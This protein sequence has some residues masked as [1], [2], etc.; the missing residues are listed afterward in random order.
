MTAIPALADTERRTEYLGL[1]DDVGP[2]DVDFDV[3]GNSTDYGQWIE[4]WLDGVKL[5]A[6]T[7]YTLDSPSGSLATLARPIQD[8]R[9]TPAGAYEDDGFTGDLQI[10]GADRPRRTS[11]LTE[12]QGVSAHDAN[13][14]FTQIAARL[15]ELWDMLK[16][17]TV[18]GRP[19]EAVDMTLPP[20]S[21]RASKAF[22]FDSDGK[23]DVAE[24]TGAITALENNQVTN[25][26]L[27][28]SGACSVIGRSAN[29]AGDPADISAGS[30]GLILA[31]LTN[32]VAF[33]TLTAILDAVIGS[34]RGMM[35][36]RGAV[37]WQALAI[38]S[39][40]ALLTSDGTDP[41]WSSAASQLP[42]G[43]IDGC[44]LSNNSGDATND[45]DFAAGK[46]RNST[47][48]VNITC[49]ALT[50]RLDADWAAGTNQ[51]MRY[52]GAAIANTTYHLYSIAK[53]DG[54]QD[55][56]AYTGLDPTAVL[57]TDY[58]YF[59]RIG[60]IVRSSAAILGFIQFGD[61]FTLKTPFD[62]GSGATIDGTERTST[63]AAVPTGIRVLATISFWLSSTADDRAYLFYPADGTNPTVTA[64]AGPVSAGGRV[65]DGAGAAAAQS[66]IGGK[67]RVLTDTNAQFKRKASAGGT[68]QTWT[69]GYRDLRGKDA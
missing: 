48:A 55:Y 47:D 37:S 69:I 44:I 63:L 50:K 35:L 41:A 52:S 66:G 11:Q 7:D 67:D 22:T 64:G 42:R 6:V 19:G 68:L 54:T 28:D 53:A 4:V 15:R 65:D 3:Y 62:E 1:T 9:I 57:P 21:E 17:R 46:C 20:V 18:M 23:P 24:L 40:G 2:F 49:A 27:R 25:A 31:R 8:T 26:F 30:N 10:I 14:I 59:R 16:I 36:V 38:G 39:S 45:I 29:S 60:S 33:S 13:Q 32:A 5:T 58:L 51:G 43:Y 34:T 12:S 61:E 56:F